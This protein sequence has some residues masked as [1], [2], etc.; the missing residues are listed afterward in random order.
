M[1][2]VAT[3]MFNSIT[4]ISEVVVVSFGAKGLRLHES[5]RPR[6]FGGKSIAIAL[7]KEPS[8]LNT[9]H[10]KILATLK[11]EIR[12]FALGISFFKQPPSFT[13]NYLI[14]TMNL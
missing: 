2:W 8:K 13:A 6:S 11:P 9:T 12:E 1:A 14:S 3:T 5:S 10:R 7:K 4:S